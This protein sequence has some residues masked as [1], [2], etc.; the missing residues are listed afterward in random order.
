LTKGNLEGQKVDVDFCKS[1]NNDA[2]RISGSKV[3]WLDTCT[4]GEARF[5]IEVMRG[6]NQLFKPSS[7]VGQDER[8]TAELYEKRRTTLADYDQKRREAYRLEIGLSSEYADSKISVN[9][10][11]VA[12]VVP[13]AVVILLAIVALLGLQQGAYR[14]H[15][16]ASL[17]Q[18]KSGEDR[19]HAIARSQFFSGFYFDT[20]GGKRGWLEIS[21]EV[22]ATWPVLIGVCYLLFAVLSSFS[23]NL[24]HLTSSIFFNYFCALYSLAFIL[25]LAVLK[26]PLRYRRDSAKP[27]SLVW[28]M[29]AS[30]WLV[31]FLCLVA[32]AAFFLPWTMQTGP[33]DVRGYRF[34]LS[35]VPVLQLGQHTQYPIDPRVFGEIRLQLLIV[36]LFL[37]SCSARV[38]FSY[39]S[40]APTAKVLRRANRWLALVTLFL[41]FNYLIYMGL[42]EYGS[43]IQLGTDLLAGFMSATGGYSMA[44][45]DP[46]PGFVIFLASCIALAWISLRRD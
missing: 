22:L 35:Q 30:R 41:S 10:L 26:S 46:A 19:E 15:L 24:I 11:S 31:W 37:L 38:L 32:L 1:L 29:V 4:A 23:T 44:A 3:K 17:N 7:P 27:V 34:F 33:L 18:L 2:S 25:T 8:V 9:A 21:P 36:L 13:F 40:K 42:L 6:L 14:R 43:T 20:R 5:S 12:E 16:Q 45:Y 28:R 39:R